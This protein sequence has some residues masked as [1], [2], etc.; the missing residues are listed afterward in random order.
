MS[1]C[2]P[3]C[4]SPPAPGLWLPSSPCKFLYLGHSCRYLLLETSSANL[5]I[6]SSG[7]AKLVIHTQIS[8][9]YMLLIFFR[10]PY[11]ST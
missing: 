5:F 4:L 10:T 2:L 11:P 6:F 3:L 7:V 1:S 8:V 9:S